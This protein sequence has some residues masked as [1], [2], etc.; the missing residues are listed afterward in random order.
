MQKVI[1][2]P[3]YL[4]LPPK[5]WP[6]TPK[7]VPLDPDDTE[8]KK[9]CKRNAQ[10]LAVK[11]C[12]TKSFVDPERFSSWS[13]LILVTARILSLKDLPKKEWLKQLATQICQWPS[14]ERR[15]GAELY[16][17]RCAQRYLDFEDP[18]IAK[19]NPFFDVDEQVFRVGGRITR[20]PISYDV[21]HPY[22]LPK[23][24]HISLLIVQEKHRHALHGGHLR[25]AAEVRRNYWLIGDINVSRQVIRHCT[26]CRRHRGK[27][28][29]QR[30]ADLPDFRVTPCSPPFK[31]TIVDYL[32]PFNVKLTRNTV[33]K[34]YCAVFTCAVTRAVHLTCVPDLSTPAFLQAFERFVSIRGAPALMIS[35]NATCFRGADNQIR[36]LVL[37]LD[38]PRVQSYGQQYRVEWKFGPPS[39]PHHQGAV[40]RLVQEVKK[41]MKHMVKA[42]KLTFVE[43][44]TI[45]CQISSL[46][47]GRPLTAMSSSPLDEPPIT[48]NHFLIGRGDLPCPQI[49]CEDHTGDLRKGRELCNVIV[50]G[51]WKRWLASIHKLSPRHKWSDAREN[52]V[53]RDI[54]L[55]IDENAKRGQWKMA[56]VVKTYIG[57]DN[58]VRV[59]DVKIS[60]G[61]ILKRPVTKLVLLM[62]N[63]ERMD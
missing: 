26:T 60:N 21:C 5:F 1:D 56:E 32:G 38:Q 52:L 34:G 3:E 28:V 59:V 35:D 62:K 50:D 45:F 11:L 41:A 53:Q 27:P 42:D 15:K 31:T 57:D 12:D 29:E 58:L 48:P 16:W 47:N 10:I 44:E 6:M 51:F 4:R 18:H 54:V 36:E 14:R 17:I 25:T 13:R 8:Q 37:R 20:A 49:P 46:L 24:N 23:K 61:Q 55:V 2:G 40:E 39:G 7:N 19:L 9:F 30:M 43:W 33:S 22:L 63:T